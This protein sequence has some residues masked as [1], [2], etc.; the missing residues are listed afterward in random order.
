MLAKRPRLGHSGGVR[1]RRFLGAVAVAVGLAVA[2]P[3][4]QAGTLA[5]TSTRCEGAAENTYAGG[6]CPDSIWLLN[7]DGTGL[8]RLTGATHPDPMTNTPWPPPTDDYPSWSPAGDAV[9]FRRTDRAAGTLSLRV[10][11]IDGGPS[12][13]IG[14]S[15]PVLSPLHYRHPQW[16]PD[17]RSILFFSPVAESGW[18]GQFSEI[19][20]MRMDGSIH[21]VTHGAP[22]YDDAQFS[23]DGKRI[24]AR[25]YAAGFPGSQWRPSLV[26]FDLDGGDPRPVF[27]SNDPG[28]VSM[29]IL[30]YAVS[31]DGRSIALNRETELFV[32][33]P[34]TGIVERVPGTGVNFSPMRFAFASEPFPR[35]IVG[36]DRTMGVEH[37]GLTSTALANGASSTLLAPAPADDGNV[38]HQGLIWQSD[39][40][41]AW[42]ASHPVA[43]APDATAPVVQL[44]SPQTA[45]TSRAGSRRRRAGY[46]RTSRDAVSFTAFDTSGI[47]LSA[48]ISQVT[49]AHGRDLCRALGPRWFGRARPCSRRRWRRVDSP[50]ALSTTMSR[51]PPGRFRLRLRVRDSYGRAGRERA[52]RF[53]LAAK[54]K[55]KHHAKPHR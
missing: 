23:Q 4:A 55:A 1:A 43:P 36:A 31:P 32:L 45:A 24:I 21:Q 20:L 27:V 39:G 25:T 42:H 18:M 12:T 53:S 5:F 47:R 15:D 38:Y 28:R 46:P 49:R 22:Y 33:M 34:S 52:V 48:S 3:G 11:P 8:R 41:P 17:G 51:L 37:A 54:P 50:A 14:P 2:T 26:S 29:N 6:H 9:L 19:Y 44:A 30:D 13:Q 40:D 35:V 10:Q 7:D 16:S